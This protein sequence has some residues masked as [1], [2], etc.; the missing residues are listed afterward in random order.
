[1]Y[2]VMA[3][4]MI[5]VTASRI[6]AM[7]HPDNAYLQVS[8]QA[9]WTLIRAIDQRAPEWVH[10][11]F[12]W[13]CGWTPHPDQSAFESWCASIPFSDPV[14]VSLSREDA[15]VFD[16][17]IG[18][19]D[20]GEQANFIDHQ[21]F[22]DRI[23]RLLQSHQTD[24]GIGKY[25]EYRPFY[26][27]PNYEIQ[28]P[29]GPSWRTMHLGL[30]VFLPVNM[31]VLAVY[32]G[33]VKSIQLNGGDRDYG[34]TIILEHTYGNNATFWTLYGHL[35]NHS[36]DYLK[37]G[38]TVEQGQVIAWIG[39][40]EVNGQWP[41]HLHFQVMLDL[42]DFEGDFPGVAA[43]EFADVWKS[44]SPFP[45]MC[46]AHSNSDWKVKI[47]DQKDLLTQRKRI[48]GHN[49]SISY[50]KPLKIVRGYGQFLYDEQGQAYLDTVNNVA[51]VGHQHPRLIE[52]AK[53]QVN[54]LNTNTRYLHDELVAYAD[55][56]LAK[57]PDPLSVVYFVNSGSEANE[58][59][60]RMARVASGNYNIVG[61]DVGYHG[62]TNTC[63]DISPYKHNS[64][65]GFGPPDWYHAIPL[66][67]V[68]RGKH[69][70]DEENPGKRYARY[71]AQAITNFQQQG[72]GTAAFIVESI[73]SCGGQIDL[74]KGYLKNCFEI[75]RKNGA[76]CIV[77]EVQVG[78]GRVGAQFWGFA[79]HDV[80]PDIVTMGKP[81][82]N[83]H[84]M[85]AVV[86]T[87]EIAEAFNNG[88]EF[89]STFGGNPVSCTIGHAV[90]KIIE[91]EGLTQKADELGQYF[92]MGLKS[93]A[94]QYPIIGDVRGRGL[95]LGFEL[96]DAELNPL[97]ASTS[98]F[99]N[100]MREHKILTSTDGPDH[101]VIKIKPPL[102]IEK[103]N[104]NR[105]L[106]TMEKILKENALQQIS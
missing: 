45:G 79:L 33:Q 85:G 58:L 22:D 62:N 68:F 41:P 48:L 31:P 2:A 91:A 80:V 66:P 65:G 60:I 17:S 24:L 8:D 97:A 36:L 101:N 63:I 18:S 21:R 61:V 50:Q 49:L 12:R 75:A 89:F 39:P 88:M 82:G 77:D 16:C 70:S 44:I 30:D 51:H 26:T 13:A 71:L 104:I 96:V 52:A 86:C 9:A 73:L 87:P 34:P 84:P 64:K 103:Q 11:C 38:Q 92:K 43:P 93:L 54:V 90:L 102:A 7:E 15:L 57:F 28:A 4:L 37:V 53:R 72:K 19:H 78:F 99:S 3:R 94:A 5:S 59:A 27:G 74:P 69:R 42:L 95:F 47:S 105:Y 25:G 56:L 83:G 81:I 98:Y 23:D 10:Y 6:N 106:G 40:R 35:S 29:E 55:A 1:L 100:R 20:L 46:C 32:P 14:A 76:Y 67:D